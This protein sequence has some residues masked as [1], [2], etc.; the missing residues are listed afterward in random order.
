MQ[1][2]IHSVSGSRELYLDLLK[3]CLTRTLFPEARIPAGR[4]PSLRSHPVGRALTTL[5]APVLAR[6]GLELAGRFDPERR[7][8]GRDWPVEAETMIGLRR[9][10]QLQSAVSTVLEEDIPGDL[11]ETGVWRGGACIFMRAMLKAYGITDR[12]VWAADSFEGLPRPDGRY[13]A[14]AGDRHWQYNDVLAISLN[15]VQAAF[16]RYGLLDEN[17]VFLK[18]WFKDTL[19]DA[20][21]GSIAVLR[22]DGDMYSST[23]DTLDA[24]YPRVSPRGY[25][26]VDDYHD[27]ANCRR[28]VDD[29]RR[30]HAIRAPIEE[31]DGHGVFW[32]LR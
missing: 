10:D 17:V 15:E 16:A 27:I 23:M 30:R 3:K 18:G 6:T 9:L 2:D 11:V 21:I 29:Y 32:R 19:P 24:L 7:A 14:D 8:D 26:I 28:A 22:L 25:I 12:K 4:V 13:D 31:I 5:L 1:P 20:P